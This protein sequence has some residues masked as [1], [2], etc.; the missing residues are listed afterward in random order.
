MK[1]FC[2]TYRIENSNIKRTNRKETNMKPLIRTSLI[3]FTLAFASC[4][5]K[6]AT[7][8]TKDIEQ[9]RV[10]Y[11]KGKIQTMDDLIAIYKDP[12]QPI[13][14]RIAAM[15]ALA[16]TKHPDALKI[17]YDFMNQSIGLN[18]ALL[19][20]TSNALVENPTPENIKAMVNGI[21]QAQKRYSEYRTHV[22]SKLETVKAEIKVEQILN[23]YA[24][25]KE[26]YML[27][28]ESLTKVM[29]SLGDDKVVPILIAIAKDNSVKISI[30]SLAL[31][32][33]GKKTHPLVTQTFIEML[34]DPETQL[35]VR[36]FAFKAIADVKESR[37][38]LALLETF[39]KSHEEYLNLLE[40]LMKALGDYNDPA[41]VPTLIEIAKDTEFPMTIRKD[42]LTA[43]IKFKDPKVFEKLLPMFENPNNFVLFDQMTTMAT[44]I[45]GT[46]PLNKLRLTALKAQQNAQV[47]Q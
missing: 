34:G 20:A 7:I 47:T 23:L 17:M 43:L 39:N 15:Q 31:E 6:V 38:L 8:T 36:D 5:S 2:L 45:G 22:F 42:A 26:N 28:Q 4:S 41:V 33:L 13:E 12:T 19:T 32:L 3:A 35:Q 16:Q 27:M 1:N 21:V 18:Y 29:G 25:E 9:L 14:T 37:V 24:A 10:D 40:A 11:N 46:A 44:Q 30:R